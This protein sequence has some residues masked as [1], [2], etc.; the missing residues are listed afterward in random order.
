MLAEF[1]MSTLLFNFADQV[2][3]DRTYVLRHIRLGS[4]AVLCGFDDA[5][6]PRPG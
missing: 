2:F 6:L 1:N 4:F 5:S 3:I